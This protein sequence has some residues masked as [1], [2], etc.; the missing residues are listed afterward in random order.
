MVDNVYRTRSLGTAAEGLRDQYADGKAARVWEVYIGD[1]SSRTENYRNFITNLLR[2]KNCK[3]VLDLACGT[4]YENIQIYFQIL[5]E[6]CSSI[7]SCLN[8]NVVLIPSC[9]LK[10]DL[11]LL[12]SMHLIKC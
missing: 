4:G 9:Y 6:K 5:Q 11:K 3:T 1:K 12:Q 8:L 2:E 7:T 10:K